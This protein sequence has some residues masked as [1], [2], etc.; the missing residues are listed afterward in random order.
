VLHPLPFERYRRDEHASRTAICRGGLAVQKAASS[1]A[2]SPLERALTRW[3]DALIALAPRPG[4][5]DR[6]VRRFERLNRIPMAAFDVSP[7]GRLRA[8]LETWLNAL[9]NVAPHVDSIEPL[10]QADDMPASTSGDRVI[11]RATNVAWRVLDGAA[12]LVAPTSPTMQVLNPVGT[13]VWE[14]ADGRPIA[15]IIDA[16]VNEFEVERS[17]VEV[18]VELFVKD[19]TGKGLLLVGEDRGNR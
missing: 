4:E 16:I 19:M 14:L 18:D 2:I 11:R 7:A 1:T 15:S 8:P 9:P 10:G 6:T 17:Q 13:R 12:V 5:Q 3:R